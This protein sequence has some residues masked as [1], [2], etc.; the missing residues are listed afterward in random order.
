[1]LDPKYLSVQ[2]CSHSSSHVQTSYIVPF[3]C[4]KLSSPSL[5]LPSLLLS[6]P[7]F[8]QSLP[9][10]SCSIIIILAYPQR[11][12]KSCFKFL[13]P[14]SLSLSFSLSLFAYSYLCVC[15]CVLEF[16]LMLIFVDYGEALRSS[17]SSPRCLASSYSPL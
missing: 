14:F 2:F 7:L 4:P 8:C 16:F 1:M 13:D 15:V 12:S 3:L 10:S 11:H 5:S 6:L 17:R 9:L